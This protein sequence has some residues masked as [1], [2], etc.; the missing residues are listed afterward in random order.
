MG[1][2]RIVIE[3]LTND[4][5]RHATFTKRKTGLIKKAMELSILCSCDISLLIVSDGKLFEYS[6]KNLNEVMNEYN[7]YKHE[8]VLER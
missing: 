1:R 8:F 6:S 4:R 7:K 2:N 5:N 3:P